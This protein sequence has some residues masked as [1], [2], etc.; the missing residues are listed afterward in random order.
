MIGS[1]TLTAFAWTILTAAPNPSGQ[2]VVDGYLRTAAGQPVDGAT[3]VSLCLY[4]TEVG[5]AALFCEVQDSLSIQNGFFQARLG[6]VPGNPLNAS[7]FAQHDVVW[8]D[9]AIGGTSLP[10]TRVETDPYAFRALTCDTALAVGGYSP[11]LTGKAGT[12]LVVGADGKLPMSVFPADLGKLYSAG[13]GLHL[14]GTVFSLDEAAVTGVAKAACYDNPNEVGAALPGWDQDAADDLYVGTIFSGDVSGTYQNLELSC[15][16]CVTQSMLSPSVIAQLGGAGPSSLPQV[17]NGTLSNALAGNYVAT[18]DIALAESPN[19]ISS[20]V[21]ADDLGALTSITV[22]IN[23]SYADAKD[24]TATLTA[25]NGTVL[26]LV[27][28]NQPGPNIVGTFPTSLTPLQPLDS[29]IG[30]SVGGTWTLTVVENVPSFS[31]PGKFVS[32]GIH[33]TTLSSKSVTVRADIDMTGHLIRGVAAPVIGSDAASKQYV[34]AKVGPSNYKTSNYS[35][36]GTQFPVAYLAIGA[37]LFCAISRIGNSDPYVTFM[38]YCT[39]DG[40]PGGSWVL[41]ASANSA[42][43]SAVCLDLK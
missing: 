27:Q 40:E 22:D 11:D 10:R 36:S 5:G 39:V 23:I 1:T 37:H 33:I 17:S 2:L 30:M 18:P 26:T 20:S 38:G 3:A 9:V 15:A 41:S 16:G 43:C 32:W 12:L 25:P 6:A 7:L 8:L 42:R 34:D 19:S 13:S 35:I 29:L 24:V 14:F 4:A 28:R 21:V 31:T